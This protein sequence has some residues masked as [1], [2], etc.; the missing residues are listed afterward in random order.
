M[1]VISVENTSL[2]R[3]TLKLTKEFTL[4]KHH[5]TVI[6]V[7]ASLRGMMNYYNTRESILVR[8]PLDVIS[9]GYISLEY[10]TLK[11]TREFTLEKN[12]TTVTIVVASLKP[13]LN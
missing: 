13:M 4:E 12:H 7:G 1:D 10:P 9:V 3:A 2:Q 11:Y 6:S 8:N 5:T